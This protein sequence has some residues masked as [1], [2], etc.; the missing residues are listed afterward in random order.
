[1]DTNIQE[2]CIIHDANPVFDRKRHLYMYANGVEQRLV[3]N[4]HL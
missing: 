3:L 4:K 2:N 1:M